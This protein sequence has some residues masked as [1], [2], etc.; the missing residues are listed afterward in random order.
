MSSGATQSSAS[1]PVEGE[2]GRFTIA[3]HEVANGDG[4]TLRT[5]D[6]F[7]KLQGR[8]LYCTAGFKELALLLGVTDGSFRKETTRLNRL[9]RQQEGG[10]A[11]TT[12][13]GISEREGAKVV[14]SWVATAGDILEENGFSRDGGAHDTSRAD[15]EAP[16]V[17]PTLITGDSLDEAMDAAR[18]P[19]DLLSSA[20]SNSIPYDRPED[21]VAIGVD[22]V[23][24]KKQKEHRA[25]SPDSPSAAQ[26]EPT[27][28]A[29]CAANSDH[30]Q[31]QGKNVAVAGQPAEQVN[32]DVQ[33]GKK[34]RPRV[35]NKVATIRYEERSY[36][37][38][39]ATYAMVLTFVLAFLLRNGLRHKAICFFVDGERCLK[40]AIVAGFKWLSHVRVILDWHHL[41]KKC[42]DV[43]SSAMKGKKLR[44]EHWDRLKTLLW[45]G[46]VPEA[47]AYLE[48]ID[49]V[50]V[51][52]TKAL[53]SLVG[54][55]RKHKDEIPC[56]AVRKQLGLRNSSNLVEKANDL[57]VSSRQ[58]HN[59]MS[60]SSEGSLGLAALTTI[61]MNHYEETWLDQGCMPLQFAEAA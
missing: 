57:S 37:M 52:S 43:L 44:N 45:Y 41:D 17:A 53:E 27:K 16:S 10:I 14:A 39:A 11:P 6:L 56:Y 51:K 32:R 38:V 19:D 5:R 18:I 36:T 23:L 54:Y 58:K 2:V 42:G 8:Q 50:Q 4:E 46:A 40:N 49:T 35:S 15:A 1:Y 31:C 34:P 25:C 55:L 59:G 28:A 21:V 7:P 12:L 22:A 3:G 30:E 26:E 47:I 20:R 9:R 24:A 61:R 60:W 13:R 33:D 48:A 29:M